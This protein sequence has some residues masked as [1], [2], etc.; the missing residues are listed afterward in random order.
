M[1][2]LSHQAHSA[3][4]SE[5]RRDRTGETGQRREEEPCLRAPTAAPERTGRTVLSRSN[6]EGN[7]AGSSGRLRSS[8]GKAVKLGRT[9]TPR[10][11]G[12]ESTSHTEGRL[13]P[14]RGESWAPTHG[15]PRRQQAQRK[16][17]TDVFQICEGR[18]SLATPAPSAFK[19]DTGE[20]KL[21]F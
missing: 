1:R 13:A 17:V 2:G 5:A 6:L 8:T 16:R 10:D 12:Q 18:N 11:G 3:T 9:R 4:A 15:S 14:P 20:L 21:N 19:L 7:S